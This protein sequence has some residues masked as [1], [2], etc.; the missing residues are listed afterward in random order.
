MHSESHLVQAFVDVAQS[1]ALTLHINRAEDAKA[2]LT[3]AGV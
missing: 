2:I 3:Q 1:Q